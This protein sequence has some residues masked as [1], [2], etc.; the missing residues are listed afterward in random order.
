MEDKE[1]KN[2][3]TAVWKMGYSVVSFC[4]SACVFMFHFILRYYLD[5]HFPASVVFTDFSF[6]SIS[7]LNMYI[8]SLARIS[9]FL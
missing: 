5:L 7:L 1:I 6:I 9:Q 8:V 2:I 3:T 4:L